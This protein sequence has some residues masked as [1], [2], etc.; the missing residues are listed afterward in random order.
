MAMVMPMKVAGSEFTSTEVVY[1]LADT[2]VTV[3][4]VLGVSA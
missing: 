2:A 1:G 4:P 3:V